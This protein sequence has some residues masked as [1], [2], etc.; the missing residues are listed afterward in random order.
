MKNPVECG[1]F[2][3]VWEVFAIFFFAESG[4]VVLNRLIGGIISRS[5]CVSLSSQ[6]VRWLTEASSAPDPRGHERRLNKGRT[7]PLKECGALGRAEPSRAGPRPAGSAYSPS[8]AEPSRA[9]AGPVA[10]SRGRVVCG[11]MGLV[12]YERLWLSGPLF[13]RGTRAGD[14][15]SGRSRDDST[16]MRG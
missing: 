3:I 6:F 4:F 16:A 1:C 5:F 14:G 10:L 12:L 9:E 2:V 15:G 8:R 13:W 11:M 7:R